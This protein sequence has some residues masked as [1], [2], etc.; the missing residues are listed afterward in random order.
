MRAVKAMVDRL[1]GAQTAT[2]PPATPTGV[3][4]AVNA[5]AS[6]SL[7][8]DP[9]EDPQ[10][11]GYVVYESRAE[12]G[13]FVSATSQIIAEPKLTLTDLAAGDHYFV[14]VAV[15]SEAIESLPTPALAVAVPGL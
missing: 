13:P 10:V 4:V 12:V 3:G 8:W 5:D 2:P 7:T 9:V 6:V 1:A 14:I 11:Q 15:G